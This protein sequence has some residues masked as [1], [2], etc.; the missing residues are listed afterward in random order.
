MRINDNIEN[1]ADDIE[2][3]C[4]Q[5][6]DTVTEIGRGDQLQCDNVDC[7][8]VF[9]NNKRGQK[10]IKWTKTTESTP[11]AGREVVVKNTTKKLF[12]YDDDTRCR[13]VKFSPVDDKQAVFDWMDAEGFDLWAY[14]DE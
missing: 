14:A 8:H 6:S 10:M 12:G 11:D 3:Y 2:S 13:I 9:D 1:P 7:S 5:C 4:P